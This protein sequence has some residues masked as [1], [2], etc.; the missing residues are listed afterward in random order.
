MNLDQLRDKTKA[1]VAALKLLAGQSPPPLLEPPPTL[2]GTWWS[3]SLTR[4]LLRRMLGITQ[5]VAAGEHF[6]RAMVENTRLTALKMRE[7]QSRSEQMGD[8]INS[9]AAY[10]QELE[11]MIRYIGAHDDRFR[12]VIAQWDKRQAQRRAVENAE[13][14]AGVVAAAE[15]PKPQLIESAGADNVKDAVKG[16]EP[17]LE[18]ME[19]KQNGEVKAKKIIIEGE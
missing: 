2:K 8:G 17:H 7:F 6:M 19:R 3:R 11:Q 12:R 1:V 18:L 10:A 14:D 15:P 16:I 13:P 9:V 5:D 4:A